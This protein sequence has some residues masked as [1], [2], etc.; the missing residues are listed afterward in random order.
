MIRCY[1][2]DV[3]IQCANGE[4]IQITDATYQVLDETTSLCRHVNRTTTKC[5]GRPLREQ[6]SSMCAGKGVCKLEKVSDLIQSNDCKPSLYLK[7]SYNCI[8]RIQYNPGSNI[9]TTTSRPRDTMNVKGGSPS[10]A[11]TE[12]R[13]ISSYLQ[14]VYLFMQIRAFPDFIQKNPRKSVLCL[15]LSLAFGIFL[16]ILYMLIFAC[17]NRC[18][19]RSNKKLTDSAHEV[20]GID[21]S[22]GAKP[23]LISS[24]T[25]ATT[26]QM[27]NAHQPVQYETVLVTRQN[28]VPLHETTISSDSTLLTRGRNKKGYTGHAEVISTIKRTHSIDEGT[29]TDNEELDS[30]SDHHPRTISVQEVL[31]LGCLVDDLN[32]YNS[33][34]DDDDAFYPQVN[35]NHFQGKNNTFN[36]NKYGQSRYQYANRGPSYDDEG[37][38]SNNS[39]TTDRQPLL[40]HNHQPPSQPSPYYANRYGKQT[41]RNA[42]E[43]SYTTSTSNA[44]DSSLTNYSPDAIFNGDNLRHDSIQRTNKPGVR[45]DGFEFIVNSSSRSNSSR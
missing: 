44:S 26:P 14:L 38:S 28:G 3:I 40:I 33:R 43:L 36:K 27:K 21:E 32:Y 34:I 8:P 23:L 31:E 7:V 9:I 19:R 15:I 20:A 24:P 16:M 1:G 4:E 39:S 22:D 6:I 10:I 12:E 37:R 35:G 5:Y 30:N 17:C 41:S 25:G 45:G 2:D 13:K 18:R 11:V 29:Q 42:S